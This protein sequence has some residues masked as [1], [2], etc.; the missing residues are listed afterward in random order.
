MGDNCAASSSAN[1]MCGQGE[2]RLHY[3]VQEQ[4]QGDRQPQANYQG[5]GEEDGKFTVKFCY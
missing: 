5:R 1:E 2:E 3:P 4:G